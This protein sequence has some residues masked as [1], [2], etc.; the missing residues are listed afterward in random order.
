MGVE[1]RTTMNRKEIAKFACGAE[2]FH[3][4]AHA[5]LW[6]SGTTLTVFGIRIT[7]TWHRTSAII[8]AAI[9]MA[10]GTYAWGTLGRRQLAGPAPARRVMRTKLVRSDDQVSD[11]MARVRGASQEMLAPRGRR[12]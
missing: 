4:V 12:E 7:P 1:G 3:A 9:S 8:N 10:L 6:L 5:T 11:S 2:A